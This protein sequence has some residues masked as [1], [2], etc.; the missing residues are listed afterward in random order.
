MAD[1]NVDGKQDLAVLNRGLPSGVSILFGRGD[2]AFVPDTHY[3]GDAVHAFHHSLAAGDFNRDGK[4][5]LVFDSRFKDQINVLLNQGDGRFGN[6]L[7]FIVGREPA[8]VTVGDFNNDGNADVATCDN[9]DSSPV[10][11]RSYLEMVVADF[12]SH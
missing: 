3:P 6:R 12:S 1:F 2:G 7:E 5:D 11:C 4:P 9:D 8:I 10:P